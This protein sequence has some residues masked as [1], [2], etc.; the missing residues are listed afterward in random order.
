[1]MDTSRLD[2]ALGAVSIRRLA[3]G[4]TEIF[5]TVRLAALEES[6]DAFGE[7]LAVARASDWS[8]RTASG[9]AFTDRGVF[10]AL[11]DERTIGMVFVRCEAPPAA[12]FL[13]GMWVHPLYRR[14]GVGRALV[15]HGLAFLRS[16]GQCR[17]SLWVSSAHSEVLSFYQTL[18]FLE[19][20]A[21]DSLRPRSPVTITELELDLCS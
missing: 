16:V 19:T 17:V 9:S 4:D 3:A 20:G 5:R 6:P 21:T 13:G 8:A 1:M 18:G 7:S 10:V 11:A 15:A 2:A 12:A 14:R